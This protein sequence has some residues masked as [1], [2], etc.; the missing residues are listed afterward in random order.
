MQDAVDSFVKGLDQSSALPP[1]RVYWGL[2]RNNQLAA[3]LHSSSAIAM[4]VPF[5]SVRYRPAMTDFSNDPAAKSRPPLD[6]QAMLQAMANYVLQHGLS[7]AS[8]RPLAKAAG[9]S[10]RM[11]IY[12]FGNK[13]ALIGALLE[14]LTLAY[15][16]ALDE[17]LPTGRADSRGEC[18]YSIAAATRGPEFVPYLALWWQI[19]AEAARGNETY[20]T[21]AR[22]VMQKLVGWVEDFVPLEDSDAA[23]TARQILTM[24]EGAQMLDA[25]GCGDIADAALARAI[26]AD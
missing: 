11:L 5:R 1:R 4:L 24:V 7:D 15:S 18:L 13:E 8:L 19:V 26:A 10:D 9:T 6:K 25:V 23:G 2:K 21:A 20:R 14:Y 16:D 22:N 17:A 12:H 3:V